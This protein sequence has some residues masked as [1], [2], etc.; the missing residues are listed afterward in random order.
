MKWSVVP[1]FALLLGAN[2]PLLTGVEAVSFNKHIAPLMYQYCSSCHRPG[3]AAPFPLLTYEDARRHAAQIVVVTARRY[4]PPWLPE[5]GYGDF[6]GER[7]LTDGQLRLIAEWVEEG[8]PEGNPADLPPPP[9]FSEGWQL[10]PPDLIARIPKPYRLAA[11]GTDVFRNFIVPVDLRETRYVRAVEMRPG[12]K[13]IVHHANILIDHRQSMR[14]RD[15]EDGQPGFPGILTTTEARSDVFDPDSHFLFW[16]PGSV[17]QPEPDDMSWRLDP[18]TD[19]ILNM[20]LRPSGK[21]ETIQPEVGFYFARQPPVKH[22]MLLQLE[23]DG[24]LDIPPGAHDFEVADHLTVPAGVDVLAIYPHAH[25]LG[26]RV[27]AWAT[28]PDG[29]RTWLIKIADWDINWQAVYTYR[30]PVRLPKGTTLAMRISYDNSAANPRNPNLAP[31]R[32]RSGP[33]SEDEMGHMW[34]QVLPKKETEEDPRISLQEAVMRRRLE[35]YPDDFVAHS[36]LGELLVTRK[37]YPEAVAHFQQALAKDPG[38]ATARNGLGAVYLAEGHIDNAVRELKEAL[39]IDP[40]HVNAH[41]NLARALGGKG[42]LNG[43]A[44]ELEK[45]LKQKADN[46]DAQVG[47]GLVYFTQHR[48]AEAL[49]HFREAA[50]QRPDDADIQTNLGV[51]LAIQGDP[52]AAVQA[53]QAALKLNP[54]DESA[55]AYLQRAQA[56]AK[57][58]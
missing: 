50:R 15:G 3:E 18:G 13:R 34:L 38:S 4:M 31:K 36:N 8:C 35:K 29:T 16:K 25:Y 5:P 53:F 11:S 1:I 52:A 22:P 49:P 41:L 17:P 19:L 56:L 14:K 48:Y 46:T 55:R 12:N 58:P 33:G 9:H 30:N 47:L 40:N 20:H 51:L 23:H 24:A 32:V 21:V 44:Q 39:R 45:V 2:R 7:R 43:A 6:V 54:H 42:D 26:K 37:Q 10:G 57:K 28:L 27:E